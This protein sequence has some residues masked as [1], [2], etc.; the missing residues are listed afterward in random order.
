MRDT[1]LES[2][3]RDD[4]NGPSPNNLYMPMC[5][6][7]F[8]LMIPVRTVQNRCLCVLYF[9][10]IK[11]RG[12]RCWGVKPWVVDSN[13]R[14]RPPL[15]PIFYYI[16]RFPF[17]LWICMQLS[18]LRKTLINL[19]TWVRAPGP[20]LLILFFFQMLSYAAS[21]Q[22][23]YHVAHHPACHAYVKSNPRDIIGGASWT[24]VKE[25][26]ASH[27]SQS[28]HE[29]KWAK[30]L[31][32]NLTIRGRPPRFAIFFTFFLFHYFYFLLI[33]VLFN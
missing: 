14:A 5:Y 23:V 27:K 10:K 16:I 24:W 21:T 32:T 12:R 33:I 22:G 11:Q 28:G 1:S 31:K 18:W 9:R 13:F 30:L 17:I 19:R 29:F 25:L 8:S 2:W 3:E 15:T 4:S 7:L 20:H 6:S 26:H